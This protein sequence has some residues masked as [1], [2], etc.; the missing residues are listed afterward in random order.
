MK[1][2]NYWRQL[3]AVSIIAL[4]AGCSSMHK[5]PQPQ[6]I[7]SA[8]SPTRY[9]FMRTQT[10]VGPVVSTADGLTLYT[11]DKDSAGKSDC[12]G[13]CAQY[14]HP[15]LGSGS[16]P[17]GHMTLIDRSDGT[18]QWAYDGKPLYTFVQDKVPGEIK[19]NDFHNV[20]HVVPVPAA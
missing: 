9:V 13:Q 8:A 2:V 19:G 7:A 12:Y 20:W 10:S 6:P 5:Q 1:S 18:Q 15:Y 4:L 14:W 17:F 3:G 11:Y 16:K